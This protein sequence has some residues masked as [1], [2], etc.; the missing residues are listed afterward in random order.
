[1]LAGYLTLSIMISLVVNVAN[2][3]LQLVER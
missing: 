3:R 1:V 2:R